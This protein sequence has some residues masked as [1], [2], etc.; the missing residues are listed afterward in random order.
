MQ[1]LWRHKPYQERAQGTENKTGSTKAAPTTLPW[2]IDFAYY[3]NAN[4]RDA[5]VITISAS[6]ANAGYVN[7]WEEPIFAS[8]CTTVKGDNKTET[9]YFYH[10]LKHIQ[11]DILGLARGSAQPHVY[12]DDIANL[13]IPIPSLDVQRELVKGIN[14]LEKEIADIEKGL[15]ETDGQKEQI[16]KKYLE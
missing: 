14:E 7:Y 1:T 4:N 11:K 16:L 8:D 6:G 5:N 10:C 12:P 3:H 9:L 13:K 2:A 15:K